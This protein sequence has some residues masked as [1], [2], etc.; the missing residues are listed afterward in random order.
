VGQKK[1]DFHSAALRVI[2]RLDSD[3][4]PEQIA[5][6]AAAIKAENL[7][8]MQADLSQKGRGRDPAI[9]Q[10]KTLMLPDGIGKVKPQ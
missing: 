7:A 8:R 1:S 10:C 6:E 9:R 5:A 2:E 3:I 4:T